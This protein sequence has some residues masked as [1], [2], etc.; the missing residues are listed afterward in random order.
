MGVNRVWVWVERIVLTLLDPLGIFTL[1]LV[2]LFRELSFF[3]NK[4]Q[5]TTR[6]FRFRA[7]SVVG[8]R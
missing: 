1:A 2:P 7:G 8:S 6:L 3:S 5:S 4:F